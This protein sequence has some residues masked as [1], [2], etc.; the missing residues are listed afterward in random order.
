MDRVL[1]TARSSGFLNLSN[2]SLREVPEEVYKILDAVGEGEKW[3][4]NVD[5]NKLSALPAAI[6]ELPMLKLLDV[7]FNLILK[8]LDEIGS[9]TSLVKFDCSSN[10][11]RE[12]PSSL[13][14]CLDLSNLKLLDDCQFHYILYWSFSPATVSTLN[15]T[16]NL[17]PFE[18]LIIDDDRKAAANENDNLRQE[19]LECLNSTFFYDKLDV[20]PAIEAIFV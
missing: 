4:E 6:E 12:L 7:S 5:H 2:R 14:G 17:K 18:V 1:K 3:W 8:V 11:L 10:Q 13:G 9:A 15:P 19:I 20:V 16:E